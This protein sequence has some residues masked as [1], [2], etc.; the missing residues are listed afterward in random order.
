MLGGYPTDGP[1]M[2]YLQSV[3]SGEFLG[4]LKMSGMVKL[5]MFGLVRWPD[6]LGSSRSR[7]SDN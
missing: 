4:V 2:G 3:T 5:G 1:L 7:H 6:Q